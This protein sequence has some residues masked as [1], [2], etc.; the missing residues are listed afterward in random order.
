MW[1]ILCLSAAIL[2]A[3]AAADRPELSGTWQLDAAKS[4]FAD[5]KMKAA[6]WSIAQ[7]D[8]SINIAQAI[9]ESN[10]KQVKIDVDCSTEGQP[11][12][13]KEAG[14]PTQVTMYYNGPALV[15]LEQLHGTEMVTKKRILLSADG[16][17]LTVDVQHLAPPGRKNETWTFVKH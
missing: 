14:Q 16:K 15:M 7:K 2:S 8:A 11:C 9:T 12:T 4:Q 6:T 17:T 5:V 1:K 13:I 10:G 3:T